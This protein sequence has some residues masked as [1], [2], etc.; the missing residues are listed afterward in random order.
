MHD[1]GRGAMSMSSTLAS[2]IK[3]TDRVRRVEIVASDGISAALWG[4]GVWRRAGC[5]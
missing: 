2:F 3:A 5:P 1:L 4:A